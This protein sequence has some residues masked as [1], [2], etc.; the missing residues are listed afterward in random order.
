M[1]I[2]ISVWK[3]EKKIKELNV[4]LDL[5]KKEVLNFSFPRIILE[6]ETILG[7][8]AHLICYFTINKRKSTKRTI[9]CNA[10]FI[11]FLIPF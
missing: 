6:L 1:V 8:L 9:F 7:M 5:E 11:K 3:E 2:N 10:L 4:L